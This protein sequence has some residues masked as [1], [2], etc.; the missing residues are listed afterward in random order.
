MKATRGKW[1]IMKR[2]PAFGGWLVRTPEG[3]AILVATH[4]D[5]IKFMIEFQRIQS[6]MDLRAMGGDFY[7][8]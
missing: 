1:L 8:R 2:D 6:S 7:D 4:Q 5:A 3:M